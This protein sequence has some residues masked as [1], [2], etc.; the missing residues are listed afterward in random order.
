MPEPGSW[1]V[2]LLGLFTPTHGWHW[3]WSHYAER[4]VWE[5]GQP[6]S[7]AHV[8]H[9]PAPPAT[10]LQGPSPCPPPA[11]LWLLPLWQYLTVI[12]SLTPKWFALNIFS[13][14]LFPLLPKLMETPYELE[15]K[16]EP[17]SGTQPCGWTQVLQGLGT[18]QCFYL[19]QL[20][21]YWGFMNN[22]KKEQ[23]VQPTHGTFCTSHLPQS[24]LHCCFIMSE[25]KFTV[26][27]CQVDEARFGGETEVAP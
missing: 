5:G 25:I 19:N 3:W 22:R 16:S 11:P 6:G 7:W 27:T 24:L 4:H 15:G 10:T 21:S 18:Q 23:W 13:N 12:S 14:K 1:Q 17:V 8:G 20:F 26:R 9:C 2:P